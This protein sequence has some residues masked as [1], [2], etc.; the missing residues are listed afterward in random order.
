MSV[1]KLVSESTSF[2]FHAVLYVPIDIVYAV[3]SAVKV[4]LT[5]YPNFTLG[6][7]HFI[8]T[9]TFIDSSLA[10]LLAL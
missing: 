3:F 6:L 10:R 7:L 9:L 8:I 1:T 5:A 2:H 4:Y